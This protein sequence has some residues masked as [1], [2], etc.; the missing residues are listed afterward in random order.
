TLMLPGGGTAGIHTML[1]YGVRRGETVVLP[2]HCHVSTLNICAIAGL[3]PAFPVLSHTAWGRAY[4]SGEAYRE[5][6]ERHPRAKAVLVVRPDYYGL[7]AD[8]Q[9]I[10]REAR[11]NGMLVLCDE[12]HGATLNWRGDVPNAMSLEADLAV[13]S[14]H[15]TLPAITPGAWLH[16]G[17]SVDIRRLRNLLTLVQTSSPSF[18]TMLALDEARAWMDIHG[19]RACVRLRKALREFYTAAERLGYARGQDDAPPGLAYDP[20]RVVLQA[21]GSGFALEEALRR[22]GVDMEMADENCV[23]GIPPLRGGEARLSKLLKALRRIERQAGSGRGSQVPFSAVP[24]PGIPNRVLSLGEAA[25]AL[26]E[27]LP[28]A[29]AAGRVSAA[30]VGRYPPGVAFLTAGEEITPDMAAFLAGQDPARMFG[31]T[32]QGDLPCVANPGRVSFPV[33]K[34]SKERSL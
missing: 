6:M 9:T 8:L 26:S 10:A 31:L 33:Q 16:G 24:P 4:T 15:K 22:H 5:T 1:L 13:Q 11:R 3:E 7:L 2:R 34:P 29:R 21:F 30:N 27:P 17:S 12:A 14:A 23:V 19:E 25:S 20:L 32:E 28:V 18:I